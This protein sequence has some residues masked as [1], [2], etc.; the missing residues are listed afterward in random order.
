MTMTNPDT[1]R[2]RQRAGRERGR[3]GGSELEIADGR[4]TIRPRRH[5]PSG[6]AVV[7]ALLVTLSGLGLYAANQAATAPPKTSWIVARH[8]IPSGHRIEADDLG[9]A[10]M[11]L[12]DETASVSFSNPDAVIGHVALSNLGVNE[13]IQRSDVARHSAPVGDGRRLTVE[14]TRAHALDGELAAGDRVDVVATGT[15]PGSTHSIVTGALVAG[16]NN[17]SSDSVGATGSIR[18]GLVVADEG[19]A[20]SVIDAAEHG[21]VTLIVAADAHG[22]G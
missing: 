4:R 1:V 6:R 3:G 18:V 19:A 22:E 15:E 17:G 8:R 5:L 12:I 11:Q 13:I 9:L 2:K 7:G 10:A 14:L 21:K 16:V 20:Q